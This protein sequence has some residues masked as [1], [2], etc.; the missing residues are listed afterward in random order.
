MRN[1]YGASGRTFIIN[2]ELP[3]EDHP[4]QFEQL[5]AR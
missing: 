1:R 5:F 3:D 2:A 4:L